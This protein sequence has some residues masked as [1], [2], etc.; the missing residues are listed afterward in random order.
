MNYLGGLRGS[1]LLVCG[2]V[3]IARTEYDFE[4]YLSSAGQVTSCGEICLPAATPKGGFGHGLEL[5]TDEGRL[6][7]LRFSDTKRPSAVG[8]VH[9]DVLGLLPAAA[10][11]Q[12]RSG[13]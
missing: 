10:D 1:G 4:G 3:P 11:W 9:V 12:H 5:R 7:R 13:E 8:A 6:L 2:N